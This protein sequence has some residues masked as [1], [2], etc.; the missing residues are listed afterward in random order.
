[1][2]NHT[3]ES[4]IFFVRNIHCQ[5]GRKPN[6]AAG[7]QTMTPHYPCTVV[8]Q[9][10]PWH[11]MFGASYNQKSKRIMPTHSDNSD[12]VKDPRA[13]GG[14]MHCIVGRLVVRFSNKISIWNPLMYVIYHLCM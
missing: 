4:C 6:A 12:L 14:P 1:M 3:L 9:I 10:Q 8:A 2:H 5:H 7:A 11:L 13:T